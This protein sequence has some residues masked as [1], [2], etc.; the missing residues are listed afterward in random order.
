MSRHLGAFS[1]LLGFVA[2]LWL[3][4]IVNTISD[5]DLER[6]GILP[7]NVTSLRGIPLHVF[8]HGGFTHLISNTGPL[9]VLGGL[10]SLRGK[11]TL[12]SATLFITVAGGSGVWLLGRSAVHI[13]ASGLAF[14]Y[15]GYLVARGFYERSLVSILVAV[16]V[17][18]FYWGL[19]F[20]VLPA[21]GFVSWEGHLF[22][23]IAGILL[24]RAMRGNTR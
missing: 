18:F 14:G 7:R 15:F 4:A 22:G 20:G 13:G 24:A 12:F 1:W 19:I 23:L 2:V 9:L 11:R 6:F 8:L 5:L 3:V 17:V 21:E 16:V 10:T